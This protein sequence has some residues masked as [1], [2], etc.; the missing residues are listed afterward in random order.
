[1]SCGHSPIGRALLIGM[2]LFLCVAAAVTIV[3][4]LTLEVDSGETTGKVGLTALF[5]VLFALASAAGVSVMQR[6]RDR[7]LGWACIA[8][9]AAG[10]ATATLMMWTSWDDAEPP[11][12]LLK[13]SG[14]LFVLAF[15]LAQ[16]SLLA[17]RPPDENRSVRLAAAGGQAAVLVLAALLMLAIVLEISDGTYYRWVGTASVLWL[18]GLALLP[19]TRRLARTP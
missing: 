4:F 8:V 1:M 16:V 12:G 18:C 6:P 5:G 10:F 2:M 17:I 15:A 14:S 11:E 19:L 9:S 7:W 13:A 3:V